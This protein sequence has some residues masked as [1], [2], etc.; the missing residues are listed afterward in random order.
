MAVLRFEPG[1]RYVHNEQVYIVRQLLIEGRLLVEN[2]SFGGQIT[3]ARDELVTAWAAGELRFEVMGANV[4]QPKDRPIA[5]N[6]TFADF[7]HCDESL[8][9]NDG[10]WQM[11]MSSLLL[12]TMICA[13]VTA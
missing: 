9:E 3:V 13:L 1:I 6:Y 4:E 2:L 12:L 11:H 7:Q 10:Q 8:K 5:T